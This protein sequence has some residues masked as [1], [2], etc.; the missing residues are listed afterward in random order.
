MRR[1]FLLLLLMSTVVCSTG[2][3]YIY[4]DHGLK[5]VVQ[6]TVGA[7]RGSGYVYLRVNVT[8]SA[9]RERFIRFYFDKK[10]SLEFGNVSKSFTIAAHESRQVTM[11]IPNI[12]L[13]SWGLEAE[14]DGR[15]FGTRL[16]GSVGPNKHFDGS[17][18]TLADSNFSRQQLDDVFGDGKPLEYMNLNLVQF[19][20]SSSQLFKDWLAYIKF[21]LLFFYGKTLA[22]FEPEIADA[23]FDYVRMGGTLLCLG[24][25]V[26]PDDFK[27]V[28]AGLGVQVKMQVFGGGF[29]Q[30]FVVEKTEIA[31]LDS[32]DFSAIGNLR[33][34]PARGGTTPV[35]FQE[36]DLETLS[37]VMLVIVIYLFA[38]LIGPVNFYLL[39]KYDQKI[40]VFWTVPAFSALF[41]FLFFLHYSVIERPTFKANQ[42]SFTYLDQEN[43]RAMTNAELGVYSAKNRPT[44]IHFPMTAAVLLYENPREFPKDVILDN[45]QHFSEGWLRPKVPRYFSINQ[46]ESRREQVQL[47][48]NGDGYNLLNGLGADIIEITLLDHSSRLWHAKN[49]TAG[50]TEQLV[51]VDDSQGGNLD[52][53]ARNH[54][55]LA[56]LY[57]SHWHRSIKDF[58]HFPEKFLGP[59]MYL[60]RLRQC[61]F[62]PDRFA[63]QA[64]LSVD[65]YVIGLLKRKS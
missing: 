31:Q 24:D 17:V 45:D 61:P 41:C 43:E 51:S 21:R 40:Y 44:G 63:G 34:Q 57:E 29:G 1:V 14:V 56:S 42:L 49:I 20:G 11:I 18:D 7:T 47:S 23:I 3:A 38:F 36:Q 48:S 50:A 26:L 32:D 39:H 46:L 13:V 4:D 55:S 54:I 2:L 25:P 33:L 27:P 9:A 62:F 65:S 12:E 6:P 19:E 59:G 10:Y 30:V 53:A 64:K 22:S 52:A 28:K 58:N 37:P 60:A 5:L 8:N 15:P 16:T 35:A